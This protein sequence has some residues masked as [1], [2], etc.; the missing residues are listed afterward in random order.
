MAMARIRLGNDEHDVHR[1]HEDVVRPPAGV[2]GDRADQRSDDDRE[3]HRDDTDLKRHARAVDHPAELVSDVRV[4]TH[5]VLRL[6][7]RAAERMDAR[8]S[9]A[10]TGF[11]YIEH[12][13][14]RRVRRDRRR[15][16]RDRDEPEQDRE[17]DDCRPLA[18]DV[19]ERVAPE[20]SWR[21]GDDLAGPVDRWL[22][23]GHRTS[24]TAAG[25]AGRGTRTRCRR[26]GSP[27]DRRSRRSTSRP[28][29]RCS[30][31]PRSPRTSSSPCR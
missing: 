12:R 27:R 10:R 5:D 30:R 19:A 6:I 11:R 14:V 17:A 16:D 29:S 8:S 7:R 31:G 9:P 25:S 28:G 2:S 20:R 18:H 3:R 24:L 23:R 4:Q 13:L 1:P 22:R 15:E 21:R 26:R